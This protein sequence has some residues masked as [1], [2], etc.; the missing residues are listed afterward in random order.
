M[1]D[2][3]IR[4][5]TL[6]S[7]TRLGPSSRVLEARGGLG[8]RL[9]R[10]LLTRK[11]ASL[12]D[13]EL[14]MVEGDRSHVFGSALPGRP[15]RATIWIH[16]PAVWTRT[17]FGGSIGAG[18]AYLDG[19]WSSDDLTAVTRLFVRNRAVLEG[20]D[21]GL[22]QLLAPL[23]RAWHRAR[24]N[25]KSAARD[26]ISAHYDLGNEFYALFLDP[27]LTYSS[28]V[29]ER[30][31]LSLEQAQHAKLERLCGKLDLRPSDHLLEI[32]TGWGSLALHAATHHGCRVTTTTISKSQ[33]DL[34]LERVRAA[35]L[36]GRVRVL[37]E[38]YRVLTGTYDKLVSVEMIEAVGAR[39]QD[40]YFE[41]CSRLLAAHGLMA[42]QA[43]V[44]DDRYYEQALRNVD[45]IQRHV[46][47]GSTIPSLGSI[48][49]SVAR[50]TD[51]RLVHSEDIGLHYARTLRLWRQRFHENLAR[52]HELG[53]DQ[54]FRRLWE[55]YLC[56]CEG[57][58]EER[59]ISCAQLLLAKPAS[60]RAPA[61]GAL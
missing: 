2:A 54:R 50:A 48:L 52:V 58:F 47:P 15:V 6:T 28:A 7:L 16:D 57:G 45:F 42:L 8:A 1:E 25:T 14:R 18:E 56:Y 31:D 30:E 51:L 19:Q 23:Q 43:I 39:W 13:G 27:S 10:S 33:H 44:I 29:F 12:S 32:G 36:E 38:D 9:A 3:A 21:S 60:R 35:G 4:N 11:L 24:D 26:N 53:F 46:F 59:Q 40:T 41:R 5:D 37:L 55:Y 22:G 34:A 61:L 20:M 17:L 49:G